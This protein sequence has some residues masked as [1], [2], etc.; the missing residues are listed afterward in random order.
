VKAARENGTEGNKENEA[1]DSL[2]T[3]D[4]ILRYLRLFAEAFGISFC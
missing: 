4:S 1:Y 3:I 2:L